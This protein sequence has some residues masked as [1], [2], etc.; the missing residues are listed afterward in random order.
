MRTQ[1]NRNMPMVTAKLSFDVP[2]FWVGFISFVALG[3]S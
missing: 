1:P 3:W 2:F